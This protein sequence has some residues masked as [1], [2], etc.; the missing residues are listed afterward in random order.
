VDAPNRRILFAAHACYL[1]DANSAALASRALMQAMARQGFTVEVL[2]GS[3]LDVVEDVD[4]GPWLAERFEGV[5]EQGGGGVSVDA[6]G[7]RSEVP[8]HF[9]LTATGIPVTVHR[10]RVARPHEPEADECAGFL[11]LL[12]ATLDRFRPHVL[13]GYGGSRIQCEAFR[14]AR[15][16][17]IATVFTLH[18]FFYT[19]PQPFAHVDAVLVASEF[20]AT[21]HHEA[22][23]LNCTA[24]PYLV[25]FDRIVAEPEERKYV[26]FV[27][28]SPEK[29][30]YPFA[31]I[32]DELG[33]LRPDIPMLVVEGRGD[34]RTLASCGLE[35]R[36]RGTVNLM[37]PTP[38]HR[39][40]WP[41]TRVCLL[42][43]LEW[44]KQ[45]MIAV[46]AM[47][48][49]I[50]VV[51]SDRGS[52]P[53]TLGKAGIVLPLP[54]RLTAATTTLPGAEEVAPWVDA[55]IRLWD[56]REWYEE[57]RLRSLTEAR[58]WDPCVL[59]PA[60]ARFFNTLVPGHKANGQVTPGRRKSVVLVPHLNGIEPETEQSLLALERTGVRVIRRVGSSQIDV[61]RNMLASEALHHGFE[62]ILFVDADIGF[63][64]M[65]A[66]RL[67]ARPEPVISGV[68]AKKGRRELASLF[69][70][71][72]KEITF[73]ESSGLYPLRYAATGF[74]RIRAEVLR[75]MIHELALPLCNKRWGLGEWPFFQ[76][77]I[78]PDP[79]GYHYLGEDWAFSYRLGQ[80]GVTPLADTSIR[81]WHYGRYPYGWEDAG[82]QHP[83]FRCFTIR[84]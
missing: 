47:A 34:E 52:L 76:P 84:H 55:V 66:L 18:N 9:R 65:D 39:D 82:T 5:E 30:V 20:S 24:I 73:G 51:G 22:M 16:R 8:D 78:V 79:A 45:P 69:A 23:G 25:D 27:N 63:D 15:D 42:P 64:P 83:R 53:E 11:R 61:A 81:L 72:I 32:A 2:C 41:Q 21:F 80:I 7:V 67:L 46:E 37:E 17:G 56:D 6:S 12:D 74:L 48:N 31:R 77:T 14:R 10:W 19:R 1:D 38:D 13:V 28:P 59:E 49:G 60:Y 70:T 29:G 3:M 75:R 4:I 33:R 71:D 68:Y 43:S 57:Q 35:L 62:S 36:E 44:E 54:D 26:T 58:R 50:P 40:F